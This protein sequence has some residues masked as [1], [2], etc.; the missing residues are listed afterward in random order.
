VNSAERSQ[1]AKEDLAELEK[2]FSPHRGFSENIKGIKKNIGSDQQLCLELIQE[3]KKDCRFELL[4]PEL[5]ESLETAVDSLE[6]AIRGNSEEA[7]KEMERSRQDLQQYMKKDEDTLISEWDSIVLK[8]ISRYSGEYV[9]RENGGYKVLD[10]S[11]RSF[12]SKVI[13][14]NTGLDKSLIPD[15]KVSKSL[16]EY[17]KTVEV[18]YGKE[19]HSISFTICGNSPEM[20][21]STAKSLVLEQ[22]D[23]EQL[24]HEIRNVNSAITRV[25]EA[26]E[27]V[28]ESGL[29]KYGELNSDPQT[30]KMKDYVA[31][32]M[33]NTVEQILGIDIS[34]TPQDIVMDTKAGNIGYNGKTRNG[35]WSIMFK[36]E[37]TTGTL[38]D[39]ME[40]A[41][42]KSVDELVEFIDNAPMGFESKRDDHAPSNAPDVFMIDLVHEVG[43][44]V[45]DM[46]AEEVFH[47]GDVQRNYKSLLDEE[48]GS[49]RFE[50]AAN[51]L[52]GMTLKRLAGN[53]G[54]DAWGEIR[55]GFEGYLELTR[56]DRPKR[57]YRAQHPI[58]ATENSIRNLYGME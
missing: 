11:I 40:G 36:D 32:V 7:L 39:L 49:K 44:A 4:P 23:L 21:E 19:K 52:A 26:R 1:V 17:E 27:A 33:I 13:C 29:P 30:E 48:M 24:K 45:S 53:I 14:N 12:I 57:G 42:D 20:V 18:T 41:K 46:A 22:I 10:I 56:Y 58:H 31:E 38:F 54:G 50:E 15:V 34:A 3:I 16:Q 47:N 8:D 25:V 5:E 51:E 2:V 37:Q 9:V 43:H 6:K 28:I 55:T 35:K